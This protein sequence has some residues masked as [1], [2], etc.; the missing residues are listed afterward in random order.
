MAN[1]EHLAIL[2]QGAEVWN[3]W[4]EANRGIRPDLSQADL[5][6]A[7]LGQT[8]LRE[9]DLGGADLGGADLGGADLGGAD[10]NW[11][12]LS[13][14]NLS[15]TL[16]IRAIL[17]GAILKWAIL[18]DAKL[19]QADLSG[20][21]LS[22]TDLSGANLSGANLSGANLNWAILNWADLSEAILSEA[23]LSRTLFTSVDLRSTIGL[24]TV[25][26]QGPSSVGVDTLYLSEGHIPET[27][28]RGCGVPASLIEY[29]PSLIGALQPIQYYSCFISYSNANDEFARRLHGR[30]QQA[31]LRVWF[32]PH[33]LKGGR[34]TYDQIDE[35]ILVYDKLILVLSEASTA[36]GWV[37][38]EIRRARK[39]ERDRQTSVL[40]PIRLMAFDALQDWSL[41]DPDTGHDIAVDIRRYF[42]PDFTDWK[43]H[44][45]FEVA[46]ANLL[47]A[48]KAATAKGVL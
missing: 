45:A 23:I 10:L 30:M 5:R 4:R 17:S 3:A 22:G 25:R 2:R 26:H 19:N 36:S 42:I 20:A 8:D 12:N 37:E 48:L 46:F 32:A 29:I 16:L 34:K 14:A 1:E 40:F 47:G 33:D 35:A 38:T 41:P 31:G 6:D 9:A 11:A 24:N 18:S 28:L 7:D 15:G 27:F 13:R 21:D 39:K 43:D 44:D